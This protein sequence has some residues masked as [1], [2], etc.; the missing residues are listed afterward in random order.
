MKH[1]YFFFIGLSFFSSI[2]FAAGNPWLISPGT[3]S[4]Q[5]S[6]V[7]QSADELY[8]GETKNPLPDDLS[9]K[10]IWVDFA[11]GLAD[12]MAI[13]ARL[14]YSNFEFSPRG[15]DESGTTDAS[16][17][18]TWR[19]R[20]E[21]IY[22]TGPSVALRVG[23]TLAG[24][25]TTE[26]INSIGDGA[27]GAEISLLVGKIIAPK[28]SIAADAGYRYRD[29]GVD[30]ELFASVR[31][32]YS[33]T[34]Q[35]HASVGYSVVRADG[36]LDLGEPEFEGSGPPEFR[37]RYTQVAEDAD[38]IELG[39]AYQF[40]RRY[41]VGFGYGQIVDGRN[42]GINDIASISLGMTF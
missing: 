5:L 31:G 32:F 12:N 16:L 15:E 36:D 26:E 25:Y 6:Y 30:D 17:G 4:I 23:V 3:K 27:S 7:S 38:I 40:A 22:D 11:Y 8:E 18:L 9:Q 37:G 39:I 21:F 35:L 14:G 1:N 28:L 41:Q 13:D 2:T 34:N 10:T 19:L 24:N 42:T 33:L 29:S 20:D